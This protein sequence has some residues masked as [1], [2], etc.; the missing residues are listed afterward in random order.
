MG[1][2][3][4]GWSSGL[5]E[6]RVRS[7]PGLESSPQSRWARQGAF[8]T[9]LPK[10]SNCV[11]RQLHPGQQAARGA[12][13][14]GQHSSEISAPRRP[15][16]ERERARERE[17]ESPLTAGWAPLRGSCEQPAPAPGARGS[18]S[19]ASNHQ[20]LESLPGTAVLKPFA[21]EV[22]L[23]TAGTGTGPS[24]HRLLDGGQIRADL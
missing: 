6:G 7:C 8:C 22:T 18:G 20:H 13:P 2:P 9:A 10:D 24:C 4:P 3:R 19:L 23:T 1:K 17:R 11:G 14:R 16:P 15:S 12:E 21:N 5:A